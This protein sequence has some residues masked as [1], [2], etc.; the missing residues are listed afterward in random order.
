MKTITKVILIVL[1][2]IPI[3]FFAYVKLTWN[4]NF[5]APYPDIEAVNDSAVIERGKYLVYGAAHCVSCHVPMD[6]YELAESGAEIP[7]SGGW[8]LDIPLGKIRAPNLTPDPETG[9][10]NISDGELA[11]SMRYLVNSRHKYMLPLM[12]FQELSDD[13]VQAIISFLRSQPPVNNEV[14]ETEFTFLGKMLLAMG[15]LSPEG[16][17]NTPPESMKPDSSMRYGKYLAKSVANCF[18]CHTARSEK[19]GQIIGEPYAGGMYFLPDPLF[20]NY[21]FISPNITP[22]KETGIMA[23]WDKD[24]FIARF[25]SGIKVRKHSPMPW[26][27]YARMDTMELKALYRYI[28]N[29][30]PVKN[31]VPKIV[32]P[33][34]EDMPEQE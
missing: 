25:K 10:G 26:G 30:D 15:V 14:P 4:K 19:D 8:E 3:L 9:I 28:S 7:L 5:T 20:R 23:N 29:L 16:P 27:L 24:A 33:P 22:D 13:D 34:G 2:C 12:P 1:V 31:E 11:R 17:E 32:F 21:G 6:K 18:G